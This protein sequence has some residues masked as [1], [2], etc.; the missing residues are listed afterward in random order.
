MTPDFEAIAAAFTA[1]RANQTAAN[2]DALR[3]LLLPHVGNETTVGNPDQA[4][5]DQENAAI[6]VLSVI[7]SPPVSTVALHRALVEGAGMV[8]FDPA[9]LGGGPTPED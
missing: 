9:T 4:L 1:Y 5:I 2:L 3:D 7:D 6:H 8:G